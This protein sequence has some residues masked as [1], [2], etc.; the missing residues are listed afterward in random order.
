MRVG[1]AMSAGCPL[2]PQL[3]PRRFTAAMLS[4][5]LWKRSQM[6]VNLFGERYQALRHPL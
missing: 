1:L 3:L 4:T 6:Q 2:V 5:V